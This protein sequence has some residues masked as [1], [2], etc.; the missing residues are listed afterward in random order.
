MLALT[1]PTYITFADCTWTSSWFPLFYFCYKW[2][3]R[4]IFFISIG[5]EFQITEPKYLMEFLPLRLELTESI[6]SSGLD[7]K[8]MILSLFTNNS[9]KL[10]PEISWRALQ[11]S[12][13]SLWIFWWWIQKDLLMEL[14]DKNL[15]RRHHK[16]F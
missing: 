10:F 1:N 3:N 11:I 14:I 8:L 9:F 16:Q 5:S 4:M 15:R 2:R 6:T 12:V 7:R 13:K